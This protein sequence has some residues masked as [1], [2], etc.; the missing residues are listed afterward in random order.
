LAHELARCGPEFVIQIAAARELDAQSPTFEES[1]LLVIE[2]VQLL[3]NRAAERLVH[4]LDDRLACQRQFVCTATAGPGMLT[5]LPARLTSRLASGLVVGMMPLGHASRLAFLHDRTE[6]RQ[7]PVGRDVLAWLAE[8]LPGSLRQ[9][10]GAVA[11]LEALV[12]LSDR[13]PD[14]TVVAEHFRVE[15]ETGRPT[16]E[17]IAEQVGRHF[18]VDP[19][20]LQSRQRSRGALVPRQIAMA[21]ARRLTALSLEQIGAYFG[22]RDHS[23]VLHAC[24]KVESGRDAVLA[25]AL[26]QLQAEFA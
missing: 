1:D 26:R 10:E 18:Q 25:G 15:V 5:Q 6:R 8:H 24:R 22:G 3:P 12:R 17:R 20:V 14:R 2:D 7:L 13:I 21:L 19:R 9:L 11:R 16:V 23:T 4:L